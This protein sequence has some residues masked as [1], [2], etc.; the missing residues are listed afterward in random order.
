M[1]SA[2]VPVLTPELGDEIEAHAFSETAKEVGGILVG[3][4]TGNGVHLVGAIPALKA[5]GAAAHVT[6]THEVWADVMKTV[7]EKFAGQQVVGWYHTHPSF[8]LFLS[9]YDLFIHRNFFSEPR[10]VALV[11]DP[12]AGDLAWFGHAGDEIKE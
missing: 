2:T 9:E 12:V 7:D 4:L 6:F 3:T 8:G 1:S 11:I 10:M 5:E